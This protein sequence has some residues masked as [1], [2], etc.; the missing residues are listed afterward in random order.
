MDFIQIVTYINTVYANKY[1]I[2]LYTRT[3]RYIHFESRRACSQVCKFV[4]TKH[5]RLAGLENRGPLFHP[6]S[7]N[8]K[9]S[10]E[11]QAGWAFSSS[12]VKDLLGTSPL[13]TKFVSYRWL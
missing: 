13:I 9:F 4:L 7:K 1:I 6:S 5:H 11:G 3:Y 10:S 2:L 8:G 12:R